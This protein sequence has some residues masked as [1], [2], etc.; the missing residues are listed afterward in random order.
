MTTRGPLEAS[1]PASV[2]PTARV[3]PTEK[4]E[5][6]PRARL[7]AGPSLREVALVALGLAAFALI[8]FRAHITHGSFYYD[9]WSN[10][11]LNA[12]PPSPGFSGSLKAFWQ[13]TG[14]RPML[15]LYMPMLYT[16]LGTHEHAQLAWAVLLVAFM[17]TA[18][19]AVLRTLGIQKVH[20][21]LISALAIIFPAS[22]ATRLWPT[23]A[24]ASLVI[25]VYLCG[26]L[27]AL[28]GLAATGRRTRIAYHAG[29]VALYLVAIATYELVATVAL[30]SVLIY[31]WQGGVRPALK[32]FAVDVTAIVVLLAYTVS[33][34][35]IDKSHSLGESVSHAGTIFDQSLTII[36]SAAEPFGSPSRDVVITLL[37]AVLLL[38]AIVWW[39]LPRNDGARR[40]IGGWLLT[41]IA[42]TLW[43]WA[44][45]AVF[46]PADP[47]YSPERLGVGNRV[48]A[49]AGV[50]VVIAVYAT[51]M[52]AISVVSRLVRGRRRG[53]SSNPRV[54]VA[55]GLVVALA[56]GIGY[57]RKLDHDDSAWNL[58]S[59]WQNRVFDSLRGGLPHPREGA[60]I[61]AFDY[62]AYTDPGVPTFAS[63]WDLNGAVKLLYHR[64]SI[65]G[66]PA[67]VGVSMICT[68]D[69]VYPS[70]DGYTAQFGARYGLAYLIDVSTGQVAAP[71]SRTECARDVPQFRPGPLELFPS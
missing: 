51:A 13:L 29:A 66:Y 49:V 25:G 20:A 46:V 21:L 11:A 41:A 2:E 37:L 69:S 31:A 16:V 27:L 35:K 38:G 47:Y 1:A 36:A 28:R 45:W 39:R 58:A 55:A 7:A 42:A 61:Y 23:A 5:V 67:V 52:V 63:N 56:L 43:A 17:A 48:N 54:A 50:C 18:L 32:R 71:R 30:I 44:A 6:P 8:V 12:Y 64:S 4:G 22:D 26:L 70:G 62:P 24:T 19:F 34:S 33:Q 15:A 59:R 53:T 65:S 40:S 60:T 9:D 68:S 10:A 57:V 14:F 3:P